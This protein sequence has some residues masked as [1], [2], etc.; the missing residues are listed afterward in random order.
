MIKTAHDTSLTQL[1][2]TSRPRKVEKVVGGATGLDL[3][4]I[5]KE[6]V[7]GEVEAMRE[8]EV[9]GITREDTHI[10]FMFTTAR[11]ENLVWLRIL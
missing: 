11:N 5:N 4:P 1:T 3:L 9:S 10:T 2:D 6:E 8:M 7:M